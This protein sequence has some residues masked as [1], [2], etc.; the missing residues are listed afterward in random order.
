[1]KDLI[2]DI[3]EKA[4]K[5]YKYKISKEEIVRLLEI[6]PNI[7]MGDFAL[8]CFIFAKKFNMNPHQVALELRQIIGTPNEIEFDNIT[9]EG[10]Y[11][12]F[13]INRKELAIKT[14]NEI[15][16]KGDNYGKIKPIVKKK[17]MIEFSSPNTHKAFHVG[18]IRGTSIG[19]SLSRISEFC[20]D[21]VIRANYNGDTGMHVAKWIWC[22]NKY[23]SKEKLSKEESWI[24]SIYVDAV[25]RLTKNKKLQE[26]VDEINRKL[27]SKED[28]ELNKL[29]EKTRKFS[30]ESLDRIYKE[31]N[32]SFDVY[33]FESE[34]EK[35]GREIVKELLEKKIA[36]ISDGA[37][38]IKFKDKN[39][40]VWVLLR[41]DG[42]VLYS[43][44][45]LALAEK[46]FNKYKIDKSIYV[47]GGAQSLHMLQ[48]FKTL[49]LMGFE[50]VSQCMHVS[51]AEIRLPT[52]KMS[53]RTG[54]NVL[55]SD[56]LNEMMAFS[57]KGIKERYVRITDIALEKKA[58]AIS[59]AAIKYSMLKQ[60]PNR[61]MVFDK[62]EALSF[63][64]DTGPYLLYTYARANSI[65]GKV[66]LSKNFKLP[67]ELEKQETELIIKLSKFQEII[68]GAYSSMN[69]APVAHYSYELSQIFNEFYHSC[70]VVRSEKEAFRLALV[71]AF[72][73]VLGSSL[74][75]LGIEPIKEM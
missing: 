41:S 25:K 37:T 27:D 75:L 31:L 54:E 5:E 48:L 6:P 10:P 34:V 1:M 66:K 24:A 35:R 53:S 65:L 57:K 14:I 49:E 17:S 60:S 45:D 63:E 33:F 71:E 7:E 74:R 68:L 36:E 40:G 51:L 62:K 9:A 32:A 19:E 4:L 28:A 47:I 69:P 43:A 13:F 56:F 18:H 59:I 8:P 16:S 12:N 72:R 11:V 29:W 2:I 46:K 22:Y 67:E 50:K 23:H 52:G 44:K 73:V 15:I 20:G 55:Y 39:L 70:Q 21:K 38:I 58:L 30:L 26:E 42:T 64:G 3:L 61:G